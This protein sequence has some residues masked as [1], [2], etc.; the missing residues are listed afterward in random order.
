[1][2]FGNLNTLGTYQALAHE[3]VLQRALAWLR[4]MP[5]DQPLGI[6]EL[7]GKDVY[8]NVHGYETLPRDQCRFES[9][10]R[11]VDLQYCI[12]GGE[13]IDYTLLA[14]LPGNSGYDAE[15]DFIFH[16]APAA[17]S[18]LRL[19]PGDFGVFFPDDA[20]RPKVN[21]GANAAVHKLVIKIDLKLFNRTS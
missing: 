19:Q 10:R 2:L 1:M 20:H 21:D 16:D 9:H 5:S 4:A 11:Y 15:K 8:V 18:T 6:V 12:R 13:L 14:R 3:P 7:Q 17:F